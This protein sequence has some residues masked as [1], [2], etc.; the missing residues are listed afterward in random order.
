MRLRLLLAAGLLLPLA[1]CDEDGDDDGAAGGTSD[2]DGDGDEPT[3][4]S[5]DLDEGI[6]APGAPPIPDDLDI[7][8]EGLEI[9][10]ILW[11]E[12]CAE[13]DGGGIVRDDEAWLLLYA[14][15]ERAP[16]DFEIPLWY[17]EA[18]EWCFA[19]RALQAGGDDQRPA[20]LEDGLPGLR[21]L[22]WGLLLIDNSYDNLAFV[23][24]C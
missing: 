7:S 8:A 18:S 4:G 6:L 11:D 16:T 9:L 15:I 17:E 21:P 19:G 24:R 3:C 22:G 20:A 2:G 13:L 23:E 1:A 5:A 10:D 14:G 12:Q